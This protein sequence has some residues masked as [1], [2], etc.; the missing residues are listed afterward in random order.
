MVTE[1]VS[2]SR[3]SGGVADEIRV[4]VENGT[5][6]SLLRV[7]DLIRTRNLG[8]SE[9]G[10]VMNAVTV[11]LLQKVYPSLQNQYS[12]TDPP[13]TH[14]YARIL[15]EAE[16]GNYVRAPENSQDY[17]EHVLPFLA[18][19]N[20][21]RPE[22]LE[23]AQMD[24]I[25]ADGINKKSVLAPLFL[26]LIYERSS[27]FEA[28]A[29]AYRHSLSISADCYPAVLGLA[30]VL[31]GQD[32]IQLLSGLI[33]QYP[34]NLAVKRQLAMTYYNMR[35]WSYAETAIAEVLQHDGRDS[36][37][38]LMRAH[39][40]VEEGQFIQAQTPLDLL[41]SMEPNN[42][43]YLFL[44]A[45]VQAEGYR[46]RDSALNYLRSLLRTYPNDDEAS[47]YA[48]RL[49][50]EST[51]PEDQIEGRELLRRL[52]SVGNPSLLVVNL[53]LQDAIRREAWREARPYLDRLLADRRSSL[54]LLN[55]CMVERGLGNNAAA[56]QSARELYGRDNSNEDA[57][58]AYI[59]ALIDTGRDD[60]AGR[61]IES[62][63]SALPGGVLKGRYYYLRS[64]LRTNDD[65]AM[66][67]LRSSLF[68][69][70]RNLNA[71]VGMFE[72]YRRRKDDNRAVFYLKQAIALA[73]DNAQVKQYASE[74]SSLLGRG[75]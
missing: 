14:T 52:L 30:R 17:L 56:L 13:Q 64:R 67:D 10:R 72:I 46:N 15:R 24:L 16:R 9:F 65:L 38:I 4:L 32:A 63:I 74:Y 6:P 61:L 42:R 2:P 60:E 31:E 48:A 66:N 62:R 23:A 43:L 75:Y 54:D 8:G 41:G 40:L 47:V 5:Y 39:V 19:I 22:R 37:F 25:R 7:L 49:L 70:P 57:V 59:T 73:P 58:N 69:D 20:E 21:T 28:A 26:G 12:V 29:A 35:D 44:R 34:D 36:R 45:R 51:R 55:A 11:T 50:L 3:T 53:A 1:N 18:L 33:I 68:E 71:L 27:L